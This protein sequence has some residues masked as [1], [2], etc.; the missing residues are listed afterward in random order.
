MSFS[1]KALGLL[2]VLFL[3]LQVAAQQGQEKGFEEGVHFKKL[4]VPVQTQDAEKIEVLEIFS[5]GCVHCY[6]FDPQVEQWRSQQSGDVSFRRIPAVFSQAWEPLARAFYAAQVL[7]VSKKVHMPIFAAI[8]QSGINL[9]TAA[10]MARLF[11]NSAGVDEAEFISVFNSF[12]VR[13]QVQQAGADSRMYRITGVPSLVV[14]GKYVIDGV[15]AGNN[16]R[17]LQ[18]VDFLVQKERDASENSVE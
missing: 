16:T 8:H 7:G 6:N 11:S 9:Q 1:F 15:M 4:S 2:L 3:G 10:Q 17:M 14:A 5:Y 12:G 18:V 13:S